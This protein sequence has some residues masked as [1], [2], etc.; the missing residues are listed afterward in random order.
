MKIVATPN[1]PHPRAQFPT[2][3]ETWIQESR[4]VAEDFPDL[5]KIKGKKTLKLVLASAAQIL[6]LEW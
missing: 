4:L 5:R 3:Q 2:T 6:K 1:S